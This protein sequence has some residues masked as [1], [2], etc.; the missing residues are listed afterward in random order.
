L[1]KLLIAV[2][3]NLDAEAVI[4]AL[5]EKQHRVTLIPSIGGFLRTDNATLLVGAEDDA[6]KDILAIIGDHCS[7]RDVELPLVVVGSLKEALPRIV[8]HGGATVMIADLESIVR[9]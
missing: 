3:H 6:A 1:S 4:K 5:E 8:R 2:V 9:L 7:S